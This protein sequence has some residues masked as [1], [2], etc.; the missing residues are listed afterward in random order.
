MSKI[1]CIKVTGQFIVDGIVN[2]NGVGKKEGNNNHKYSKTT[3]E[4]Q[5]YTGSNALRQSLFR[6]YVPRQPTQEAHKAE[7]PKIMGSVVGILRGS[8]EAET[9]SKRKSPI[10]V[11]KAVTIG[12]K[13]VVHEQSTSSKPKESNLVNKK[14]KEASDTSIFSSDS[15]G[16]RKQSLEIAL[17]VSDLQFFELGDSDSVVTGKNEKVFLDALAETMESL[18]VDSKIEKKDYIRTTQVSKVSREG[19]L[20][21]EEQQRACVLLFLELV[22]EIEIYRRDA[23][24]VVDRKSLRITLALENGELIEDIIFIDFYEALKAKQYGFQS[25]YKAA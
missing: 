22:R 4:G 12:D 3:A 13:A 24:L 17:R 6:D 1:K 8:L 10:T 19:V 20:L 5:D 14:G 21:N 9:G 2:Y 18:G 25:F 15:A 16:K 11:L 23:E 7:F